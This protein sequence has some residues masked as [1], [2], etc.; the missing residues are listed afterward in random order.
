MRVYI[1]KPRTFAG[2]KG[3]IND[4]FLD[5]SFRIDLGLQKSREFLLRVC[6]LGVPIGTEALS[7]LAYKYYDDL[8]TWTA[9]GARTTESQVHREMASAIS[10]P[11]GFKNSTNGDIK[12][13]IN[14]ILFA[15]KPHSYLGANPEGNISV[16]RTDGNKFGHLILRGSDIAP[17]YYEENIQLYEQTMVSANLKPNIVVD[18]SHG[19]SLKDPFKQ[20]SVM[21]NIIQQIINGRK[22][23]VG[24]MLESNIEYGN[25]EIFSDLTKMKYGCSITDKCLDWV[26]TELLIKEANM[27]LKSI[28]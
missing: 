14:A 6:E 5:E 9:I 25:Q 19:N 3:Y 23:L 21:R 11:I 13:A 22:S 7:P 24:I 27:A 20:I 1:E 4:P 8:V 17:N 10:S 28:L 18:C 2:W 15:S 26:R 12:S 16:E